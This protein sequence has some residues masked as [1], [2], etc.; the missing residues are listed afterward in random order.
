M[1][2]YDDIHVMH[3]GCVGPHTGSISLEH[4]DYYCLQYNHEGRI[5]IRVGTDEQWVNG[6]SL[7]FTFPGTS[8]R[9]GTGDETT[10]NH[11]YVAFNGPRV[12]RYLEGELLSREQPITQ[13]VNGERFLLTFVDCVG[14]VRRGRSGHAAAAHALEGLLLQ[15]YEERQGRAKGGRLDSSVGALIEQ[16]QMNPEEDWDFHAEAEKLHVSSGHLRRMVRNQVGISPGRLL[17]QARLARAAELLTQEEWSIKEVAALV[18][19]PDIHY[20]TK[21]F[22]RRYG[23]PPARFRRELRGV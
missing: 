22:R 9:F 21:L 6:P 11:N 18:A 8:F 14:A 5:R 19:I 16:V 2:F 20:F 17:I 10:W 23:L 4:R 12:E 3:G 15:L 1:N 7:L 13:V